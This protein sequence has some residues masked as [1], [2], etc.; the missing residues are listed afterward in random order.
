[1]IISSNVCI[2]DYLKSINTLTSFISHAHC[3]ITPAKYNNK[4]EYLHYNS[5]IICLS[6][7]KI[8]FFHCFSLI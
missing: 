2:I 3:T 8:T 7:S 4:N 6:V 5:R 1:M